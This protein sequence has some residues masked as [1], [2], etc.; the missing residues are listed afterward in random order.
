MKNTYNHICAAAILLLFVIICTNAT[1]AQDQDGNQHSDA[2]HL[3]RDT[4]TNEETR[5][6][7]RRSYADRYRDKYESGNYRERYSGENYHQTAIEEGWNSR[8]ARSGNGTRL[9]FGY[10]SF[11]TTMGR[12]PAEISRDMFV[13]IGEDSTMF[14]SGKGMRLPLPHHTVQEIDPVRQQQV[15][16]LLQPPSLLRQYV[17]QSNRMQAAQ[18]GAV[19]PQPVGDVPQGLQQPNF[20][21]PRFQQPRNNMGQAPI[22]NIPPVNQQTVRPNNDLQTNQPNFLPYPFNMQQ[23]AVQQN[24][25]NQRNQRYARPNT[26]N[27]RPYSS[28]RS[29]GLN[30]R[31]QPVPKTQN[32]TQDQNMKPQEQHSDQQE[33]E[34]STQQ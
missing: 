9:H 7:G 3:N 27:T 5:E 14:Y 29:S 13:D 23:R 8:R 4:D 30:S 15:R 20:Q 21:Q 28:Q 32:Q 11:G 12:P 33:T 26:L 25:Q 6:P 17:R 10:Q 22:R 16:N 18:T 1:V 31:Y 34:S 2:S 19:Q 24:Q